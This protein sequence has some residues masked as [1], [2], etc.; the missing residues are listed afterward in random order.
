MQPSS[1]TPQFIV[2]LGLQSVRGGFSPDIYSAVERV[3]DETVRGPNSTIRS[4]SAA[5]IDEPQTLTVSHE[6]S[7]DGKRRNSAIILK[8]VVKDDDNVS[9]GN[10]QVMLKVSSDLQIVPKAT[11]KALVAVLISLLLETDGDNQTSLDL[12]STT[13]VNFDRFLNGE[14]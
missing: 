14:H 9:Y 8:D 11:I 13:G 5:P 3:Y 10:V 6:T 2:S 12:G 7:K 4:V 1:I